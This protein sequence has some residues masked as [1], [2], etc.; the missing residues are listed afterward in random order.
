MAS[1]MLKP[2]T[3]SGLLAPG[4]GALHS[5]AGRASLVLELAGSFVARWH[6]DKISRRTL[7]GAKRLQAENARPSPPSPP[8]AGKCSFLAGAPIPAVQ[9]KGHGS[10]KRQVSW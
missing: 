7:C 3:S 10:A 6:E 1:T 9:R 2:G 4:A 5:V 8:R